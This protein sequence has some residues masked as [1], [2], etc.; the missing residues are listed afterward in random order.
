MPAFKKKNDK[1]QNT[2]SSIT[3]QSA[4]SSEYLNIEENDKNDENEEEPTRL[5]PGGKMPKTEGK[6]VLRH[7]GGLLLMLVIQVGIPL[8]LYYGL[9]NTIGVVYAL[10]ISGI[11]P[12]I[13]VIFSFIKNRKVD[14]L[15]LIIAL[16][17]ILSGVVSLIS[18]KLSTILFFFSFSFQ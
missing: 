12:F 17:F 5:V 15:G 13:W 18:G 4:R 16:S 11:P 1:V 8:A 9:R 7:L 6:K 10:V 14:A 3:Q 2:T